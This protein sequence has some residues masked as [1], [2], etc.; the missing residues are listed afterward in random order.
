MVGSMPVDAGRPSA[1]LFFQAASKSTLV[2]PM[3]LRDLRFARAGGPNHPSL[4]AWNPF[5]TATGT[6]PQCHT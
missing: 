6:A 5:D 1:K 3:T 2:C 4:A